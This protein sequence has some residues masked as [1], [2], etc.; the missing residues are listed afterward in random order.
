MDERRGRGGCAHAAIMPRY[1]PGWSYVIAHLAPAFITGLLARF[2]VP[3]PD[4]M[5]AG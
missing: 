4:P 3:G 1:A 5:P 2:A